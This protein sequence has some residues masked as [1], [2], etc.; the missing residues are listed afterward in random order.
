MTKRI[1]ALL[2]LLLCA[3]FTFAQSSSDIPSLTGTDTG[4]MLQD[5]DD[6]SSDDDYFRAKPKHGTEIGL[7][8]GMAA[9]SSDVYVQKPLPGWGVGLHVRRAANYF[10]SWRFQGTYTNMWGQDDRPA[11][12]GTSGINVPRSTWQGFGYN[13]SSRFYRNYKTT[14]IQGS[15]HLIINLSNLL[16]HKK[17]NKWNLY[18]IVGPSLYTYNTKIN[19]LNG[20]SAYTN[21]GVPGFPGFSSAGDGSQNSN[22]GETE[23]LDQLDSYMDDSY[24]TE[25]VYGRE[26]HDSPN[27]NSLNL[28]GKNDFALFGGV[29]VGVGLARKISKNLNI[30]LEH[31]ATASLNDN[32]DGYTV[33]RNVDVMHF[34]NLKINF[35]INPKEGIE[36]LYWVNPMREPMEDIA[37][38]KKRPVVELK[39]DD[40]D[41]VLNDFDD[42][43]DTP[44]GCPVDTRGRRLDSDGDGVYDCDDDQPYTPAALVSEVD[45][46]GVAS[47]PEPPKPMSEQDIINI[48]KGQGWDKK[49]APVVTT[50]PGMTDWFLPMIHFDLDKYYLKPEA[51]AQLHHVAR[52][53]KQYP[54]ICVVAIGHTDR[55]NNNAYNQVLSYNRAKTAV[56]YL[57]QVYGIDR[58]RLKVTYGG[59]ETPLVQTDGSSYINRRVEFKVCNGESDMGRPEGPEAGKGGFSAPGKF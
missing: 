48:G 15:F 27:T 45:S 29:D 32:I 58:S 24:E 6:S 53:M 14:G 33:G 41:G 49:P 40:G 28:S 55:L 52:V 7:S 23:V 19:L 44:N 26:S 38:L 57:V 8:I 25:I 16:F 1:Y 36:P 34:T 47:A 54:G 9:L 5:E 35:N 3:G 59:E 31:Q 20:E 30:A 51:K 13:G 22:F 50:A 42:E 46:K 39:D 12:L 11:R 37:E 43:P 4:Y 2:V 18:S 10:L 17:E 56:D 21:N